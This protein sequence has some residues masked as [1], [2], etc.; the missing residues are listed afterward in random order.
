MSYRTAFGGVV[1]GLLVMAVWLWL[2]VLEGLE[3]RAGRQAGQPAQA[4]GGSSAPHPR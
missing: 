4:A 1:F 2:V 3:K